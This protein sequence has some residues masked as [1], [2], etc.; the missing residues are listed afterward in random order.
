MTERLLTKTKIYIPTKGR[1]ERQ[2]TFRRLMPDIRESVVF[3]VCPEEADY[4]RRNYPDNEVM[5]VDKI[6]VPAARQ[7]VMD[8]SD[9]DFP[10]V[11]FLDDDI[12]F[13]CRIDDW[14]FELPHMRQCTDDD[15][16]LAFQWMEKRLDKYAMV[17][18]SARGMNNGIPDR[19]ER[20]ASR[21]MRAFGVDRELIREE[22]IRFDAF[23]FWEDFHVTLSLLTRGYPNIMSTVYCTD[24]TTNDTGGVSMYRNRAALEKERRRF[25][26]MWGPWCKPS[27]KRAKNWSNI[28]EE[29]MPDLIVSWRKAYAYGLEHMNESS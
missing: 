18:L 26:E 11:I 25:L 14:L 1:L 7:A 2:I 19:Y 15:V 29:T 16:R 12:R 22:A 17:G 6:G 21:I 4:F 24:G 3:V 27:E 13:V 10:Y 9:P 28:D 23:M 5:V 8:I 20:E